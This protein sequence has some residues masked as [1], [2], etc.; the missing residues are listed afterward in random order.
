MTPT[1]LAYRQAHIALCIARAQWWTAYANTPAN[2]ARV[3]H[4]GGATPEYQGAQLTRDELIDSA[5]NVANT[6]LRNAQEALDNLTN[7]PS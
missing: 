4:Y 1:D 3:V 5:M 2:L 7:D 6:H